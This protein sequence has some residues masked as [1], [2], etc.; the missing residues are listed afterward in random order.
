[1]KTT[2]NKNELRNFGIIVGILFPLL[3]GFI[4]PYFF[5]HQFRFW[6]LFIGLPLIIIGLI[7]PKNL[8]LFY[9]IWIKIGNILGFI[10]SKIILT[11]IFVLIVQPIALIMKIVGYDPLRRKPNVSVS[12]REVRKNDNIDLEKIF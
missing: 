10:N 5:G 2:K 6:T 7:S 1:M 12:Y 9:Q 3:I 8:K 11:S 4:L